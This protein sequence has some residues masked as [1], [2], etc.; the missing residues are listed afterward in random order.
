MDLHKLTIRIVAVL[1]ALSS[2]ACVDNNFRLDEVSTEVTLG[3]GKTTIPLGYLKDKTIGS[4]LTGGQTIDGL[5]VDPETGAYSFSY[6]GTGASFEVDGVTNELD[7]PAITSSFSVEYP[8]FELSSEVV[9]IHQDKEMKLDLGALDKFIGSRGTSYNLPFDI[10]NAIKGNLADEITPDHLYLQVPEQI[11][12][13]RQIYFKNVET[14]HVGAPIHLTLDLNDLKDING[15][16]NLDIDLLLAGGQF[17]MTDG[18]GV[19]YTDNHYLKSFDIAEGDEAI[20]IVLYVEKIV[21][22]QELDADHALDIPL[23]LSYTLDFTMDAKAGSF[24][25]EHLPHFNI[26]AD[27]EYGDADVALNK[28]VMLVEYHP[29]EANDVVV[30]NIPTE[31]ATIKSIAMKP[32]THISLFAHGLDWFGSVAELIEV[33]I[34]LPAYFNLY[35]LEGVTY[36]Y[37]EDGHLLKASLADLDRGLEIGLASIEFEGDGVAPDANGRLHMNFAPD[38]KVHFAD[39]AEIMVS[40]LMPS[41]G[42]EVKISTGV[43]ATSLTVEAISGC[44]AYGYE[45]SETIQLGSFSADMPIEFEG[46][47]LSPIIRINLGNPLTLDASISAR[48]VPIS[49]GVAHPDNAVVFEDVTIKA[50][51]YLDGEIIPTLTT[52]VLA[53]ESHRE[54]F[55]GENYTFIP[56]AVGKLLNGALPDTLELDLKVKTDDSQVSTLYV[57]DSFTLTYGYGIDIPLA[58]NKDVAIV[59]SDTVSGLKSTFEQLATIDIKVGDVA[60]IVNS[61]NTAPLQFIIDAELLDIYGEPTPVNVRLPEGGGVIAGSADG[62]EAAESQMRLV[63]DVPEDGL[64]SIGDVDAIRIDFQARGV[65]EESAPLTESQSLSVVL[66]LELDG[67]ITIDFA[68]PEDEEIDD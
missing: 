35:S 1:F 66:Q 56:C 3:Q 51:H 55:S 47:G 41:A 18:D 50:A 26:D 21:N 38:I 20:D 23:S 43:E 28:D 46:E 68:L 29:V 40:S 14:G 25:L 53:D 64:G 57:A 36:E 13:I 7:V 49:G 37:S 10:D 62:V 17:V 11:D 45:H 32:D 31:I 4:M 67:G 12:N 2:V 48:L 42:A 44:I 54:E 16:G 34:T 8:K 63:L 9:S 60:L 27:F 61:V 52:L 24:S 58:F 65:G 30:E 19:T 22:N 39:D 59:Y 15:G 6:E 33:D 5:V